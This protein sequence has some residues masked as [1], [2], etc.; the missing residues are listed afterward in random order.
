[1]LAHRRDPP[2]RLA[3]VSADRRRVLGRIEAAPEPPSSFT[4]GQKAGRTQASF[5]LPISSALSAQPLC[6]P[7]GPV[8]CAP[9]PLVFA[10]LLQA[11][12]APN[13]SG[14]ARRPA[15]YTQPVL[16]PC[17]VRH[18]AV[19]AAEPFTSVTSLDEARWAH[20]CP[21]VAGGLPALDA[22]ALCFVFG[23]SRFVPDCV[24]L[25]LALVTAA[26]EPTF[27]GRDYSTPDT[28]SG[29]CTCRN[30]SCGA[31]ADLFLPTGSTQTFFLCTGGAGLYGRTSTVFS[32]QDAYAKALP[33]LERRLA[34]NLEGGAGAAGFSH[35]ARIC[36]AHAG[37]V[38]AGVQ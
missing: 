22:P 26:A 32:T 15:C 35:E 7:P 11:A 36:V 23:C 29:G 38:A 34:R 10:T 3:A 30:P 13:S 19:L 25:T 12:L 28:Q 16:A 9:R 33:A 27:G 21:G 5:T 24:L 20:L 2:P 31:D 1:M 18:V 17:A 8:L 4:C 14:V 37:T 6:S